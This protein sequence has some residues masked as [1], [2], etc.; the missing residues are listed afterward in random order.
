[1][2]KREHVV[3]AGL[4]GTVVV[5]VGFASGLGIRQQ[6]AAGATEAVPPV[7]APSA[8][9]DASP[10]AAAGSAAGGSSGSGGGAG[11]YSSGGAGGV[12]YVGTPI[13]GGATTASSPATDPPSTQPPT[14]PPTTPPTSPPTSPP[15]TGN[16]VPGCQVG[17]VPAVLN[18]VTH[19][20]VAVPV[21]G[22]A[23]GTLGITDLGGGLLNGVAGL[24]LLSS[25][26]GSST[27]DS[28]LAGIVGPL[29]VTC[30]AQAEIPA[31]APTVALGAG[32]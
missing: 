27:T 24:G 9:N 7:T 22:P 1:M 6:P 23:L 20:V 8:G 14:Q 2:V 25:G 10:P 11:Y 13:G 12:N 30:V 26:S 4:V 19:A 21:A 16:P 18:T 5:V 3:A 29:V 31:S 32:S 15:T 17:L 28:P